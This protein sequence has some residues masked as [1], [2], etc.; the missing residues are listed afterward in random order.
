MV[1]LHN[2]SNPTDHHL[3]PSS[4]RTR[5]RCSPVFQG[6]TLAAACTDTWHF[7]AV[8]QCQDPPSPHAVPAAGAAFLYLECKWVAC[9]FV[10][11]LF[12]FFKQDTTAFDCCP[13]AVTRANNG[14]VGHAMHIEGKAKALGSLRASLSWEGAPA[15]FLVPSALGN[16]RLM[17]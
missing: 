16:A 6:L 5:I 9:T 12:C 17:R 3:F 11:Y 14:T 8:P 2:G 1:S 15:D 13:T 4:W 7:P 10:Y